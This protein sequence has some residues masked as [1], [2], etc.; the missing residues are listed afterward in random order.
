MWIEENGKIPI[1]NGENEKIWTQ[2][3]DAKLYMTEEEKQQYQNSEEMAKMKLLKKVS[4]RHQEEILTQLKTRNCQI[5]IRFNPKLKEKGLL[6][7]K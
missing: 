5:E 4:R 3:I 1:G 7:L 2:P 6:D